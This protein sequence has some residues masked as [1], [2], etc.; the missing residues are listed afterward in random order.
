VVIGAATAGEDG[1]VTWFTD[2]SPEAQRARQE[3]EFAEVKKAADALTTRLASVHVN[4]ANGNGKE[5]SP[6]MTLKLFLA[7]GTR[8]PD[9][10][11]GELRRLVVS[12]G[13]DEQQRMRLAIDALFDTVVATGSEKAVIA[14]VETNTELLRKLVAT[15]GAAAAAAA[16]GNGTSTGQRLLLSNVGQLLSGRLVKSA[17]FVVRHLYEKDVLEADSIVSWAESPETVAD[18]RNKVAPL[19]EF[20]KAEDD[21]EE[22]LETNGATE[23]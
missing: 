10:V 1:K 9:D 11:A 21:D 8:T 17:P 20:L 14:S 15:V 22:A 4:T 5:D 19:V 6:V 23:K 16:I 12:R 7:S 13:L 3:A 2:T 18:V